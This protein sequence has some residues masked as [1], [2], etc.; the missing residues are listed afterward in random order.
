M[1]ATPGYMPQNQVLSSWNSYFLPGMRY[2]ISAICFEETNV[3]VESKDNSLDIEATINS[4]PTCDGMTK[5]TILESIIPSDR[6][7]CWL[8][9][10]TPGIDYRL[11]SNPQAQGSH[12]KST[13]KSNPPIFPLSEHSE[14]QEKL[15]RLLYIYMI[16]NF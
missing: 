14:L 7:D 4:T 9:Q 8:R 2:F 5:K 15:L 6:M 1:G 10:R 13:N 16:L 3:I 12:I 11:I